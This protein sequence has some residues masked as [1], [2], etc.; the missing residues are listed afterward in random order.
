M[1]Q[2]V[3]LSIIWTFFLSVNGQ[4]KGL[5]ETN[6]FFIADISN[7]KFTQFIKPKI[8]ESQFVFLGE[9]HGIIEV[10]EITSLL[11]N[12][13]QPF[14]FRTLCIETDDV[15]AKT[16]SSFLDLESPINKAKEFEKKYPFTIPFYNNYEDFEMFKNIFKL[17]GSLWG[18]DQSLMTQ[19]RYNFDYIINR[20]SNKKLKNALIPLREQAI[21]SY[22][23]AIEEKDFM[24]PFIFQY[25]ESIHQELMSLTIDSVE[26]EI[27]EQLWKTK[28]IY[29]YNFNG[30]YYLNNQIRGR[31]MKS[32]FMN[33]Y[34]KASLLDSL[35]KVVFKLGANHAALGLTR[36]NIYDI[37]NL[38][39]E[40]AIMNGMESLHILA[41]G[42][43]GVQRLAN[44]FEPSKTLHTINEN[45]YLPEEFLALTGKSDEKYLVIDT[46]ALRPYANKFSRKVKQ[47][48]FKFDVIILIKDAKP[49]TSF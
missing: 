24:A 10:G 47:F 46:R 12:I 16:L 34:R 14:G 13:A 9:Q 23:K 22:K 15:A 35:P 31:L 11:Y 37:S 29:E 6:S 32:N 17:E 40:L 36:T 48:I 43:S 4:E 26:K 44:P 30:E 38:C 25:S 5:L 27:I 3:I 49:L 45:K 42:I 19:F 8:Q 20:T 41:M 39:S 21:T 28:E 7:S 2:V 18:I 33:Y 1:K